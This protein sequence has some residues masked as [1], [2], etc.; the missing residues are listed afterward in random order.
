VIVMP[1][2]ACGIDCEVCRLRLL[3]RCSSCGP[4]GSREAEEKMEVQ[5]RLFGSACPIL[6]CASQKGVAH[7]LRD[8]QE[9]PCQVFAGGPYPFSQGYLAMQHRRRSQAPGAKGSPDGG[10]RSPEEHWESLGGKDLKEI[11][12]NAGVRLH[13]PEGVMVPFLGEYFLVDIPRHALCRQ[14]HGGWEPVRNRMLELVCLVYLLHAGPEPMGKTL[15]GVQELKTA[16]F[17]RGPHALDLGPLVSRY[18]TDLE[19]FRK[20]AEGLRGDPLDMAD[21]AYRLWAFPKVPLHYL[22][23]EGD[24]EFP[25]EAKVLFD[26]SIE[27]HLP[28]DAIWALVNLVTESLVRGELE[29]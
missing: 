21:A 19:G 18:G 20:A 4:G 8:C 27:Y 6:E 7:C 2:A 15:V 11:S 22:F 29:A 13:P 17:F 10:L 14:A 26:R 16:H 12:R 23:W 28:A 24:E 5:R 3:G 9:F 25:A 1:T